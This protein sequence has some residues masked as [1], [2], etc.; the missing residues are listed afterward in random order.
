MHEMCQ[1]D[2]Y[3]WTCERKIIKRLVVEASGEPR[4]PSAYETPS[5][6]GSDHGVVKETKNQWGEIRKFRR[7]FL[8]IFHR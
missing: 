4:H 6:W 1:S 7:V 5:S 8:N 2:S 3:L